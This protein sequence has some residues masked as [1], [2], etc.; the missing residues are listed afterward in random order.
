[1][2]PLNSRLLFQKQVCP[3]YIAAGN[4]QHF[5]T[6]EPSRLRIIIPAVQVVQSALLVVYIPSVAEGVLLAHRAVQAAA[7]VCDLSLVIVGIVY[8][9]FSVLIYDPD[10]VALQVPK[11]L[12][13]LAPDFKAD[14]RVSVIEKAPEG[15][16]GDHT[17]DAAAFQVVGGEDLVF[18]DA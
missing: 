6:D 10:D 11:V 12:I 17:G 13:A 8:D 14:Q 5:R 16:I 2:H 1:M 3:H 4:N 18:I 9:D 15:I 7:A